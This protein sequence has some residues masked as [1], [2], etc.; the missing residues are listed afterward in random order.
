[1]GR[2]LEPREQRQPGH[3]PPAATG[4]PEEVEGQPHD[5]MSESECGRHIGSAQQVGR[6]QAVQGRQ[7]CVRTQFGDLGRQ[8]DVEGIAS[9]SPGLS[10][11]PLGRAQV[12]KLGEKGRFNAGWEPEVEGGFVNSGY[13]VGQVR[14]AGQLQQEQRIATCHPDDLLPPR[15]REIRE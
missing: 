9:D 12:A 2:R 4:P 5:G 15:R 6:D 13:R 8:K 1:M 11:Q 10:E 3:A 14:M 7:R